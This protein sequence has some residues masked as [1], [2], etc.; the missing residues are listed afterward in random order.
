MIIKK[1]RFELILDAV[2]TATGKSTSHYLDQAPLV[3]A[4]MI[5]GNLL[6]FTPGQFYVRRGLFCIFRV[7]GFELSWS[8]HGT[9]FVIKVDSIENGGNNNYYYSKTRSIEYSDLESWDIIP[10]DKKEWENA[11]QEL[12]HE[13]DKT[14][15]EVAV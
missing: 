14:I 10:S 2:R 11:R 6:G 13:E 7:R 5:L 15:E 4:S 8:D 3:Q 9:S 12:L 1:E